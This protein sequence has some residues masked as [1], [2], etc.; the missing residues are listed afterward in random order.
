MATAMQFGTTG[1][2]GSTG[3]LRLIE[4]GIV[5][6]GGVKSVGNFAP[7]GIYILA[8]SQTISGRLSYQS[9]MLLSAPPQARSDF[10]ALLASP[11]GT[12][13]TNP[14]TV[15]AGI[16][17]VSIEPYSSASAVRYALYR[18]R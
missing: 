15:T 18:V 1:Q 5:Q 7:D 12:A 17:S 14:P 8:L 4:Q 3:G 9:A 16:G 10:D 6:G 11:F 2:R 13:G